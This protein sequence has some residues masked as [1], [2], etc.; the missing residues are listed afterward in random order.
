MSKVGFIGVG[1]MG[2]TLAKV[3]L[4]NVGTERLL[5]SSRTKEKSEAEVL[6]DLMNNLGSGVP[7]YYAEPI[8]E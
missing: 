5:V 8:G 7:M 3:V 6:V 1:N 2:G 4:R